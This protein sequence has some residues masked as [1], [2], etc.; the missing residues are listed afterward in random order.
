M[1]N[2]TD[3]P[4]AAPG[5]VSYRCKG[6]FGWIM[7]G[8]KDHAGAFR[9]ALRSSDRAVRESLQVWD[10]AQYVPALQK[11]H[12]VVRIENQTNR[13]AIFYYGERGNLCVYTVSEMHSEAAL[14]YYRTATRPART[15][16]EITECAA[17]VKHY[18]DRLTRFD[19][20]ALV[21]GARLR[22]I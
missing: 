3:N 20:K 19:G 14:I 15:D 16:V 7:I 2:L 6:A 13:A 17:L 10:G 18:A 21:I 4:L 5:L 12:A 8:A 11:L 1:R 22:R 9:E